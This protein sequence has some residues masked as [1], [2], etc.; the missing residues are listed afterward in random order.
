MLNRRGGGG[1]VNEDNSLISSTDRAVGR[2][3]VMPA[4][5]STVSPGLNRSPRRSGK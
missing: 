1:S 4:N 5:I 3:F 2:Y